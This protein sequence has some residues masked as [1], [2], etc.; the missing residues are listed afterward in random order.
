MTDWTNTPEP[1]K[2][3][4]DNTVT[5]TVNG[6]DYQGWKSVR[7]MA[8][9]EQAARAFELEV[10]RNY[11]SGPL[12]RILPGDAVQVWIGK[13]LICTGHVDATPIEYDATGVSVL[14][15]GRS[16]TADL[17]DSSADNTGG[18]FLNLQPGAI[19]G[20]LAGQYGITTAQ[21]A[22]GGDPLPDHQIQPGETAFESIDRVATSRQLLITDD[23]QGRLVVAS[24]GS[25]GKASTAIK[26][27]ENVLMASCGLDYSEVYQEYI[28]RGQKTGTDDFFGEGAAQTEGRAQD[29]TITRRRTIILRQSGQ[30]DNQTATNRAA[31]EAKL[32]AAKAQEARYTLAGW[33]Q[34]DGSLWTHNQTVRVDD[35]WI[36]IHADWLVTQTNFTLSDQTGMIV[37][38]VV[39]P[40]DALTAAAEIKQA[41]QEHKKPDGD[42]SMD[43]VDVP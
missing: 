6:T 25:A 9:V 30:V 42:K 32:R 28:V 19:I 26:Q 13:D 43:W 35:D 18:Q 21:Q 3:A 14:I 17:I 23:A 40:A 22:P 4:P 34:Q 39:L 24:P 20:Q 1:G 10:T 16:N 8:G 2:N 38:L 7:I 31:Y 29:H 37:E 5:L 12:R 36:G 27:G 33:R 15:R 11:P 41:E